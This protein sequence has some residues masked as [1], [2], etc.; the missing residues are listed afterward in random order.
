[1]DETNLFALPDPLPEVEHFEPLIPDRG[2]LIERI[3]SVGHATPDGEWYDQERDE[4]VALLQGEAELEFEAGSMLR[5]SAGDHVLIPAH[6]KHRVS[7][8]TSEPPCIW[9][10]VHGTLR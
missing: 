2:I 3:V 7:R 6:A 1:M 8:T 5:M 9:L 10:A 4:W